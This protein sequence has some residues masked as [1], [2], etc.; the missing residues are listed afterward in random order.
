MRTITNKA[1]QVGQAAKAGSW[2]FIGNLIDR[3]LMFLTIPIFTVLLTTE[4]YGIVS[5][6]LSWVS[7]LTIIVGVSFHSCVRNAYIEFKEDIE[8]FMS[9]VLVLSFIVFLGSILIGIIGCKWFIS[10]EWHTLVVLCLIQ[11][12]MTFLINYISAYYMMNYNYI[13]KTLL[14]LIPNIIIVVLSLVLIKGMQDQLY[15]GRIWA[16]VGI[17]SIVG[18]GIV[19]NMMLKGKVWFNKRYWKYALKLSLPLVLHGLST[20]VLAQSDR[21]MTTYYRGASE[22]AIYSL[23]Y[24]FAMVLTVIQNSL[25][26]IWIPWFYE[27]LKCDEEHSINQMAKLYI[28]FMVLMTLGIMFIAPE[29]VKLA[30]PESYWS[31]NY[32][33]PPIVGSSFVIF[34]YTLPVHLEYFY[35][36]TKVISTN[37]LIA[38]IL[39]LV[40]NFLLIPR[41]GAMAAAYTT[42]CS[43]TVSL[44][45]HY[46]EGK[47]L[48][49]TLFPVSYFIVPYSVV[50][51][52]MVVVNRLMEQVYLR[53]GIITLIT[54]IY[55]IFMYCTYKKYKNRRGEKMKIVALVPVKLNNERLANKNIRPFTNGKPLLTYILETLK[56]VKGIDEIYVY[57]SN[58]IIKDYLPEGIL[59]LQRSTEFD[60]STTKINQI[61]KAFGKEVPADIYVQTHATAP[62][63]SAKS[64]EEGLSKV[65]SGTYDSSVAVKKL[66][67]FLWQDGKTINFEVANV[68][69]TQDLPPIY[70]ETNGFYIYTQEVLEKLGCRTGRNPYLYEVSEIESI[71]ID[72]LDDFNIADAIYNHLIK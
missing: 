25:E 57:C 33:I 8:S 58:P 10:K 36:K 2:Y 47:K 54:S 21:I 3:A 13:K 43:Y 69:R 28:S 46:R 51:I 61:I 68:P 11:S 64:I 19:I 44:M 16:Y 70:V 40:L 48:K 5:T 62:F 65:V 24:S 52:M 56:Q 67:D 31:G 72:E 34:L 66:Q 42:L 27:R 60:Q 37:T 63:V 26:G 7:I 17:Q 39:N 18:I 1:N 35:K 9:S 55:L 53:W 71:D 49:K 30:T 38:A 22:T 59:Y 4:E 50:M 32:M 41:Y 15:M 6:Y 12:Y 23:I 14:M 45:I 20:I 29:I